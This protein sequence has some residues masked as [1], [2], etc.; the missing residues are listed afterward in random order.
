M[1]RRRRRE[2][3]SLESWF[4]AFKLSSLWDYKSARSDKVCPF[5]MKDDFN[6]TLVNFHWDHFSGH[7]FWVRASSND[8]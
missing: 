1:H 3:W 6:V 8:F 5:E 7:F 4:R 2:S